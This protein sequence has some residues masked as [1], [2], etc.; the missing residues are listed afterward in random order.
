MKYHFKKRI[1]DLDKVIPQV[2]IGDVVLFSTLLVHRSL[3]QANP[4][5]VSTQFRYGNFTN[6][7]SVARLWPVGQ[8]EGRPFDLDHPEYIIKD[9]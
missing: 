3:P 7:D 4:V 1:F 9:N 5:R 6:D 2:R 8:L